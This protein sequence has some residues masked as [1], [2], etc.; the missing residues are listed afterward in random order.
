MK[1]EDD[2]HGT[3]QEFERY[4]SQHSLSSFGGPTI[5]GIPLFTYLAQEKNVASPTDVMCP[6]CKEWTNESEPCCG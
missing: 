4:E 2:V 1:A 6:R 3:R 5:N